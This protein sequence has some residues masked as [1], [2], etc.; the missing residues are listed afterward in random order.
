VRKKIITNWSLK[1]RHC[2]SLLSFLASQ[3]RLATLIFGCFLAPLA[4]PAEKEEATLEALLL[5]ASGKASEAVSQLESLADRGN[6]FAQL[7]LANLYLVGHFVPYDFKKAQFYMSLARDAGNELAAYFEA[8]SSFRLQYL[9]SLLDQGNNWAACGLT[10]VDPNLDAQC[11]EA[12]KQLA[13]K[14]NSDALFYLKVDRQ[15][16]LADELLRKFP[17]PTVLA[18]IAWTNWKVAP[19]KESLSQLVKASD[20]GSAKTPIYI[21][22]REYGPN[23]ERLNRE[24]EELIENLSSPTKARLR[25]SLR[26]LIEG[27][28]IGWFGSDWYS[29]NA[30]GDLYE[31]GNLSL[32]VK[33]DYGLAFAAYG[34]CSVSDNEVEAGICLYSQAELK[35]RGGPNLERSQIEAIGLYMRASDR[36]HSTS[37]SALASAF[38]FGDGVAQSWERTAFY[39][40][41]AMQQGNS[42]P[43]D[44]LAELYREG[45]GVT[46]DLE[47]AASLFELSAVDVGS[48]MY[49]GNPKAM[50]A[51]GEMHET[52]GIDGA[53]ESQ[54]AYWFKR[55]M[56]APEDAWAIHSGGIQAV[57]TKQLA[58][59]T[60]GYERTRKK[61]L[62][63]SPDLSNAGTNVIESEAFGNYVALIIANE[64]YQDLVDLKTPR[65]DAFLV[66]ETLQ[67]RFNA[68]V[69]YL[70]NATR[71]QMLRTLNQY[72]KR[73]QPTDN[74]ILYYAGHGVY[75]K[76]LDVGYW[77]P[78]DSGV[79]EDYTWVDTDRISRTMSGFKSRNALVIADSCYAGSVLRGND[80][81]ALES[82]DASALLALSAKKTRMA[83][84]SGGLQ[85]V[86]DSTGNS[87]TS[88]FAANFANA[89]YSID[90][91]TPIS[92]VFPNLRSAVT[93]E[94]AAW[95]FEQVPEMAPLYK[96]G[97]DGG[98]FILSPRVQGRK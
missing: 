86:L 28:R 25:S 79:D 74:F 33:P 46:K 19:D 98:D 95:G 88:A 48:E 57:I 14:G 31:N 43:V 22:E 35:M 69:E 83:I 11:Y 44:D 75:D 6:D 24:R 2:A 29:N 39:L 42:Y 92:S 9:K 16:P 45:L 54:A 21:I 36:G 23:R 13:L 78:V 97:H 4:T 70:F 32:G 71:E 84:T 49:F 34:N 47:K 91:P 53:S 77:Q 26:G 12:I 8:E 15:D 85:P 51:L 73:L 89:L 1:H 63:T 3:L 50:I 59:A 61:T 40:E 58:V 72:R 90:Q 66:G 64:S 7:E 80:F 18:E 87:K 81:P 41:L 93:A 10:E 37:S 96:A 27:D 60:E 94:S 30:L 38:R 55:A 65:A 62:P 82:H 20:L 17:H 68:D 67:E 56:E 76:E 52:G 5:I